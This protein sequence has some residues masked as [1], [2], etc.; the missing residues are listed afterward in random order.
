MGLTRL[1]IE[2]TPKAAFIL[3]LMAAVAAY[4]GY[5]IVESIGPA[6]SA[7]PVSTD[8]IYSYEVYARLSVVREY[9]FLFC[10]G[11]VIDNN[12][13]LIVWNQDLFKYEDWDCFYPQVVYVSTYPYHYERRVFAEGTH[14]NLGRCLVL[15]GSWYVEGVAYFRVS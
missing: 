7:G 8:L 6:C 1:G 3:M 9:P 11:P 15:G 4:A 13:W 2:W 14:W 10:L 12:V 5:T